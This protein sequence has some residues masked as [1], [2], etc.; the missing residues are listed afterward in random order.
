MIAY[1]RPTYTMPRVGTRVKKKILPPFGCSKIAAHGTPKLSRSFDVR[2]RL[3]SMLFR[4]LPNCH[5]VALRGRVCV[6]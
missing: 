6:R 2:F 3:A 1:R 5:A 4:V